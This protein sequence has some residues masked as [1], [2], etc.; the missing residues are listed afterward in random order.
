MNVKMLG[1]R[2]GLICFLKLDK[3]NTYYIRIYSRYS[4]INIIVKLLGSLKHNGTI[5]TITLNMQSFEIF[6]K[7]SMPTKH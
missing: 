6:G 3:P 2:L 7:S 4:I 5:A 1:D